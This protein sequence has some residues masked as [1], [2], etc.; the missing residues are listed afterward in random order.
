MRGEFRGLYHTVYELSPSWT[1]K[2]DRMA[3]T[4]FPDEVEITEADLPNLADEPS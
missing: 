1:R 3:D 4:L 2:I